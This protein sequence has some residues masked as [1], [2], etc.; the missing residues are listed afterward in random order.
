MGGT[1]AGNY[2]SGV[3]IMLIPTV[4]QNSN[5]QCLYYTLQQ[6]TTYSYMFP[7]TRPGCPTTKSTLFFSVLLQ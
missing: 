4:K 6:E 5:I 2:A 1:A 7:P 3:E